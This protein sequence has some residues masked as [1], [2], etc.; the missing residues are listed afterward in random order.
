MSTQRYPGSPSLPAD[1]KQRVIATFKHTLQLAK[2]G[3]EEEANVGCDFILK[4]DPMFE[5]AKRLAEKLRYPASP[6]RLED[7]ESEFSTQSDP[8][9]DAREAMAGRDF[10]RALEI[11]SEILRGDLMNVDAQQI[12]EEAQSKLEAQ[13]FIEQFVKS[14]QSKLDSGNRNGAQQDLEKAKQLDPTHPLLRSLQQRMEGGGA[15]PVVDFGGGGASPFST[16]FGEAAENPFGGTPASFS[17]GEPAAPAPTYSFGE[18][19]APAATP[20][21]VVDAQP[22]SG[23]GA[24]ASDFGF[25]FEEEQKPSAANFGFGGGGGNPFSG[26]ESN[27]FDFTTAS[28]ETTDED[29]GKIQRYISDG[30]AAYAAGDF[31]TAI[32]TWSK[33]FLIDVTNDDASQRIERARAKRQESDRAVEDLVTA[34]TAA[35]ER[36][37]HTTARSKFEQVLFLDSSNFTARDYLD[38]IEAGP[39]AGGGGSSRPSA[40]PMTDLDELDTDF[41]EPAPAPPRGSTMAPLIPPDPGKASATKAKSESKAPAPSSKKSSSSI[42][43]PIVIVAVV[44]ALGGGGYFAYNKFIAGKHASNPQA[45]AE[46]FTKAQRLAKAGKYDEAI[47]LLSSIRSDDPEHD[48]ALEMMDDIKNQKAQSAGLINGRPASEVFNSLVE[49][50]KSSFAAHDYVT[51]KQALDQAATIQALPPD[52]KQVA[53]AAAQQVAKLDSAV[54]LLKEGKY[55]DGIAN[56]EALLQADPQNASIQQLLAKA[57][58]NAGAS[59][60]QQD[61]TDLAMAEFD[62]AL[63]TDPNDAEAKRSRDL[64]AQYNGQQKDLMYKIYVKYLP[65]RAF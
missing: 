39:G 3:N 65:L 41:G 31:Q 14:A 24:Q 35:F 15:A 9:A 22:S 28:V 11:S 64:A 59:A 46:T 44:A 61:R 10:S 55:G 48:K 51:A 33:I 21:F 37:D 7:L 53:D 4:L 54:L 45:T 43:M 58:F 12:A 34:G 50:G 2:Q 47:A 19:A 23:S 27:T 25:T 16:G 26:A 20:S 56:L 40:G 60:L 32:D 6:I 8:L 57:H 36:G 13:P 63:K 18:P 49:K 52:A 1:V 42:V 62:Q 29:R 38:R 5:P 17:F 30:D